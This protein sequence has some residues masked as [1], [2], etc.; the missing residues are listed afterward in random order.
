LHVDARWQLG[1]P[2]VDV[3]PEELSEDV[4]LASEAISLVVFC[5]FL[6]AKVEASI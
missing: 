2:R 4:P 1:C 3:Q 5:E 6:I